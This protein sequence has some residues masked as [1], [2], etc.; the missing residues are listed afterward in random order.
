M[1]CGFSPRPSA[2]AAM[3]RKEELRAVLQSVA[4]EIVGLGLQPRRPRGGRDCQ[5][6]DDM[7]SLRE[8]QLSPVLVIVPGADAQPGLWSTPDLCRREG[9]DSGS[10]MP[11]V[12]RARSLG[13]GV[14]LLQNR[15][16]DISAAWTDILEN[17]TRPVFFV[18]HSQGGCALVSFLEQK[19][20]DVLSG[21]ILAVAFCDS[22]H[23]AMSAKLA[24]A[25]RGR[26]INW[27]ISAKA[28]GE[29]WP[30]RGISNYAGC[31]LLSAGTS[32][33][34]LTPSAAMESIIE[35]LRQFSESELS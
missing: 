20:E 35:F 16:S 12:R 18:A 32:K 1:K 31:E 19:L 5:L 9:I 23:R 17:S 15:D 8:P 13:W 2:I 25:L 24:A 34:A 26:C 3:E 10:C 29:R 30:K 11:F 27:V 22:V 4:A 21:R 33:H 14:L 28:V 6:S 7:A